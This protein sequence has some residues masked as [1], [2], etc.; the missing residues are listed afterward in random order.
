MLGLHIVR[1]DNIAVVG[2]LDAEVDKRLDFPNMKAEPIPSL[3][4]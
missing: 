1:G 4:K 3:V 2:E